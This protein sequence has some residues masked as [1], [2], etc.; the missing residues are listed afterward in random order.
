MRTGAGMSE[1]ANP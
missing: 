1:H